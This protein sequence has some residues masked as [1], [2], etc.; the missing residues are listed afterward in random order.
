MSN[1]HFF[2]NVQIESR[3]RASIKFNKL[4]RGVIPWTPIKQG[5]ER[6]RGDGE[7]RMGREEGEEN[8]R[9]GGREGIKGSADGGEEGKEE[10]SGWETRRVWLTH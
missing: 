3:S 5:R 1:L 8:R 4:S 6:K 10:A 9:E 7:G 2:K